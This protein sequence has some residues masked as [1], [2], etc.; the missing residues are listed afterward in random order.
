LRQD[1][2][3]LMIYPY[4]VIKTASVY[5]NHQDVIR[6]DHVSLVYPPQTHVFYDLSFSFF[7]G[8]FY[9]LTGASGAGK[10]TLL[11]LIYKG[12]TP[13]EGTVKVFGKDLSGL[14]KKE[15]HVFRQKVGLV[16]Q[17]CKLI[18]H[19][20]ALDNV[21]L[22]MK[23][24]GSDIKK[25]RNYAKELLHWVGLGDHIHHA[26]STLSDGQKQ[27]VAIARAV[28]TKPILLLAD[29]PTGNVDDANAFRMM[30]LFEE[31]N[32]IGTTIL[33]ATHNKSIVAHYPYPQVHIQSSKLITLNST[34][35]PIA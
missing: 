32:K 23:I 34:D 10:T 29:E 22:P 17:D 9:F 30:T 13:T 4:T 19:L 2:E 14:S 20:D 5:Q 6:F 26:P 35:T 27:R 31:L 12:L 11:K 7:L 3:K 28:I 21:A 18:S 1:P 16:F 24:A 25:S 15:E 8:G 33:L